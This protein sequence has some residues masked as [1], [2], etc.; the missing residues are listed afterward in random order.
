MADLTPPT[1]DDT[2]SKSGSVDHRHLLV[3]HNGISWMYK[4]PLEGSVVIGRSA[5]ADLQIDAIAISRKHAQLALH[6][7]KIT[8]TDLGSHNGTQVNHERIVGEHALTSGD[9]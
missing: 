9:T 2:S 8:I 4:L 6:P 7:D 3:F 5:D 1:P